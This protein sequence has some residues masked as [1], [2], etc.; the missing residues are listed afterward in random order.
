MGS[1]GE[2]LADYEALLPGIA[3]TVARPGPFVSIADG[4]KAMVCGLGCRPPRHH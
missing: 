1:A 4:V 2:I 3:G